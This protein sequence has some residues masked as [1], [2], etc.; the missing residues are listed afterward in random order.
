MGPVKMPTIQVLTNY[1]FD[2]CVTEITSI[3]NSWIKENLQIKIPIILNINNNINMQQLERRFTNQNITY[4][5]CVIF[6]YLQA[7]L[8]YITLPP[9]ATSL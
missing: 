8:H 9:T 2:V 3:Y 4:T 1:M 5:Q 7:A 6:V